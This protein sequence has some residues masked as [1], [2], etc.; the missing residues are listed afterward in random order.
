MA[1]NSFTGSV[2]HAVFLCVLTTM[3]MEPATPGK[4]DRKRAP[5]A[6][7]LATCTSRKLSC[8]SKLVGWWAT[9]GAKLEPELDEDEDKQD[10]KQA[11]ATKLKRKRG[12]GDKKR[13]LY[14]SLR[15]GGDKPPD[16]PHARVKVPPPKKRC[17]G[18][19]RGLPVIAKKEIVELWFK[20]NAEGKSQ[21]E[22]MSHVAAQ[23]GKCILAPGQIT[24]WVAAYKK[25]HWEQLPSDFPKKLKAARTYALGRPTHLIYRGAR[26]KFIIHSMGSA[27]FFWGSAGVLG[28]PGASWGLLW[29]SGFFWGLLGSWGLLGPPGACVI[30]EKSTCMH[31]RT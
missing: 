25:H 1:G 17:E 4:G 16:A 18:K 11:G 6:L 24:R 2:A 3:V 20:F 21:K 13:E 27:G 19:Q 12:G 30:G 22:F 5:P 10:P 29:P 14:A 26:P 28:S 23:A 15:R 7:Q 8:K 31:V 9:V